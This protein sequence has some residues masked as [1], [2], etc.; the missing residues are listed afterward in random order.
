MTK[1]KEVYT[2]GEAPARSTKINQ[3]V[4]DYITTQREVFN[5]TATYDLNIGGF[6]RPNFWYMGWWPYNPDKSLYNRLRVHYRLFW[7]GAVNVVLEYSLDSAATW[8]PFAVAGPGFTGLPLSV[9]VATLANSQAVDIP[10]DGI[11]G[12]Q[13]IGLRTDNDLPGVSNH[14]AINLMGFLWSTTDTPF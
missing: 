13:H 5:F 8:V 14:L 4:T 12:F 3:W 10:L 11:T 9:P 2:F 1:G 7:S 6:A